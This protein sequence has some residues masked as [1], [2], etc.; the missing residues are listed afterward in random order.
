MQQVTVAPV[1]NDDLADLLA[2]MRA[3]CDFYAVN[4]GDDEL[5]LLSRALIADP[6]HE[7]LQLIARHQD[8]RALGFA[9]IF[10]SWNTLNA[11][12]LGVM[13]DLYVDPGARGT[14]LADQL[15]AA[16]V[17]A[18]R[19]HGGVAGLSWQTARDNLRAQA[20]YVRVGAERAEWIDYSL[21]L[22]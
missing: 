17:E 14:G 10:W 3:Y 15:I 6:D 13:N 9:T 12:R 2:L 11:S 1:T 22:D 18:S 20:V 8:G 5:L 21:P 19:A 4:P 16:C 7:G